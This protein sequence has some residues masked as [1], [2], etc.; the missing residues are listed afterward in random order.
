MT[1]K[2]KVLLIISNLCVAMQQS[3]AESEF[4][5]SALYNIYLNKISQQGY[6]IRADEISILA[7]LANIEIDL[8]IGNDNPMVFKPSPE[9]INEGYERNQ[10]LWGN[11]ERETIYLGGNHY[12]RAKV[13][14]QE[15]ME[16]QAQVISSFMINAF[17]EHLAKQ[18]EEKAKLQQEDEDRELAARLQQEEDDYELAMKLQKQEY[19][20]FMIENIKNFKKDAKCYVDKLSAEIVHG[21]GA[22][23]LANEI[24]KAYLKPS[25]SMQEVRLSPH[26][27]HIQQLIK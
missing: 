9:M 5:T 27:Q 13:V 22:N 3:R 19:N 24:M 10:Q 8:F 6:F 20:S 17:Q 12:S 16:R 18:P 7:S 21:G 2:G 15:Q 1:K 4:N 26:Q 25:C 11:K 23:R 14:M